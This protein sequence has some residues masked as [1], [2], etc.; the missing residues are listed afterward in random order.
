MAI[1][2]SFLLVYQ[3][4]PHSHHTSLRFA[5]DCT[6]TGTACAEKVDMGENVGPLAVPFGE[7]L[8]KCQLHMPRCSMYG[9]FTYIWLIFGVNAVG[10]YSIHGAYGMEKTA[11]KWQGTCFFLIF[12]FFHSYFKI[13]KV[14][15][16]GF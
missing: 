12:C 9:I 8:G 1:F 14:L 3:R 13:Q 4:V 15:W 2:N 10:K 6:W 11:E 7:N 5:Q 16:M